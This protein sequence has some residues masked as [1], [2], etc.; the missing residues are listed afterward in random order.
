MDLTPRPQTVTYHDSCHLKRG[1]GIREEPRLLLTGAGWNLREMERSDR[2]C[3]FGGFYSFTG[4]PQISRA[5]TRDKVN[6]ILRSGAEVVATDC[7]GC[8][9][10]LRGALEK[11][12]PGKRAAHTLELLGEALS[13][14]DKDGQ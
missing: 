3:G 8:L 12:G 4:H 9:I 7:P 14:A 6:A 10:M 2:C 11:R 5:I 1:C 13:A